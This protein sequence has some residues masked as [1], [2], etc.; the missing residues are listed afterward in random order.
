MGILFVDT[1]H[2]ALKIEKVATT[3]VYACARL[4]PCL[5]K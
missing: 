5:E 4:Q 2:S 3:N 1:R